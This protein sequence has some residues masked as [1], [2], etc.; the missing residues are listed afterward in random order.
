MEVTIKKVELS[1]PKTV[2]AWG[3]LGGVKKYAGRK[4]MIVVLEE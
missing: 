2:D 3:H 1:I 4:V